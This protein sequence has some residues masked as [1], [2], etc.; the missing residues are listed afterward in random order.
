MHAFTLLLP[1]FTSF[2]LLTPILATTA[3]GTEN[4]CPEAF[5]IYCCPNIESSN[6][7]PCED[8]TLAEGNTLKDCLPEEVGHDFDKGYAC[9]IAD[10]VS[11][12]PFCYLRALN[13]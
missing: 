2:S 12:R 5:H 6:F 11:E 8:R 4:P 3:N 9:C 10:D 13:A 7:S 1:L